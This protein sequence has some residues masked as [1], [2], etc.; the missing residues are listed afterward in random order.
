METRTHRATGE[1]L[2]VPGKKG[3]E[4]SRPYNR[5]KTGSGKKG[6]RESEGIVVVKSTLKDGVAKDPY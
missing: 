6:E 3:P 4:A 1:A 2:L 5:I